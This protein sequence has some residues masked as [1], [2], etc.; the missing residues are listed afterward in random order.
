MSLFKLT[1]PSGSV[2]NAP[3]ECH[4][5][6]A[7]FDGTW[8]SVM[9]LG[10]NASRGASPAEPTLR[11]CIEAS[12]DVGARV[13]M[14]M[15][16]EF[17]SANG[18]VGWRPIM[19]T[20]NRESPH[21]ATMT[22]T[23][24]NSLNFVAATSQLDIYMRGS[25][26]QSVQ[27]AEQ[28]R[29]SIGICTGDAN[30]GPGTR[31]YG[32]SFANSNYH[33]GVLVQGSTAGGGTSTEA[34][35]YSYSVVTNGKLRERIGDDGKISWFYNTTADFGVGAQ[36]NYERLALNLTSGLATF[37]GESLGTGAANIGI[38]FAPK[39]TGIV[40][41]TTSILAHSGTA[42]PAGGTAGAGLRVSSTS[43]FGVFF[44]SGAPTLAAAKGSIYLRSDGSAT[45]NRAYINTDG[46]TTWTAI[47]TAA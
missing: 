14:E 1:P 23:G 46:G 43:N 19:M 13:D 8:D 32:T 5:G 47:T 16:W 29:T 2:A 15:Y 28:N 9:Y 37:A 11:Q 26:G 31:F 45:N 34:F 3:W 7:T 18:A 20:V 4:I 22:F 25:A 41:A 42:I 10:Y 35:K 44:G 12:Y 38:A 33:G 21:E 27:I 30:S 40:Q 17:L 39:G 36:S 24:R 6:G